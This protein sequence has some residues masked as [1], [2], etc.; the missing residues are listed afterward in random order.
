[1]ESLAE[2]RH[3]ENRRDFRKYLILTL[4]IGLG[5]VASAALA[6]IALFKSGHAAP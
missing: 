6:L 2:T 1:V 5:T 4:L 3:R